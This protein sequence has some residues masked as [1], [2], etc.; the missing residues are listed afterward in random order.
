VRPVS[1]FFYEI[2]VGEFHSR[3]GPIGAIWQVKDDL[4]DFA[5]RDAR[6]N[7]HTAGD[8]RAGFTFAF[9]GCVSVTEPRRRTMVRLLIG[10]II[11]ALLG[12]GLGALLGSYRRGRGFYRQRPTHHR[13]P[14]PC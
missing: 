13:G 10:A 7:D 14:G 12:G 11:G 8:V 5:V 2:D 6:I 1:D 9:H 4:V 3:S